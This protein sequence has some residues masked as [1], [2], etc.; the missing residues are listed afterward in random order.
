MIGRAPWRSLCSGLG[1]ALTLLPAC[2]DDG[3]GRGGDTETA[4]DTGGADDQAD[5]GVETVSGT[6]S[7][8]AVRDLGPPPS[9]MTIEVWGPEDDAPRASGVT[10]DQGRVFLDF[11]QPDPVWYFK[12]IGDDVYRTNYLVLAHAEQLDPM[13]ALQLQLQLATN[14]IATILIN[15]IGVTEDPNLGSV[16]ILNAMCTSFRVETDPPQPVYF[17]VDDALAPDPA[18]TES[19][20]GAAYLANVPPGPLTLNYDCDGETFSV[21]VPIGAGEVTAVDASSFGTL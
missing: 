11:E 9:G 12:A 1:L 2:S 7:F 21:T 8:R 16:G 5:S 18:A 10:D 19:N 4:D 6:W 14:D 15:E 3:D 20:V 13:L 17:A